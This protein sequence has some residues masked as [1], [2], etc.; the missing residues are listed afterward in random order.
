M[1]KSIFQGL[2]AFLLDTHQLLTV[3]VYLAFKILITILC[4]L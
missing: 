4:K 3:D 1:I 2:C